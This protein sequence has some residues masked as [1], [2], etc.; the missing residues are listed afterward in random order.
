MIA[1]FFGHDREALARIGLGEGT[2]IGARMLTAATAFARAAGGAPAAECEALALRVVGGRRAAGERERAVLVGRAGRADRCRQ[3]AHRPLAGDHAR[4][5]APERLGVLDSPRSSCG[6]ACTCSAPATSR[7]RA[8]RC[9]RRNRLQELWG[10]APTA[11]SWARGLLAYH[12]VL[13]GDAAGARATLGEAPAAEEES[14]GAN[15]WRRAHAELLLGDGPGR[16]GARGRRADGSHRAPRAAPR[17][18]AVAVAEGAR[19]RAARPPRRGDRRDRGRARARARRR[20]A[21]ARSA[22]ACAS[23]ASSTQDAERPA[24]GRRHAGAARRRGSSTPA[25]W[26]R[27]APRCAAT[28]APPTRASRCARRSSWPRRAPARRSSSPCAPSS[29]PSGARPRTRGARR[30]RRA[31]RQRAARGH[32]RRRRADEPRDRPGAVRD[33]EDRRGPPVE[34]LPQAR[35]PLAAG[36]ARWRSAAL[37]ARAA[38]LAARPASAP[39]RFASALL[40][41]RG[42]PRDLVSSLRDLGALGGRELAPAGLQPQVDDQRTAAQ[43]GPRDLALRRQ[44]ARLRHCSQATRPCADGSGRRGS[45]HVARGAASLGAWMARRAARRHRL[46]RPVRRA[47]G[48]PARQPDVAAGARRRAPLRRARARVR[49]DLPGRAGSPGRSTAPAEHAVDEAAEVA[50]AGRRIKQGLVLT[51][52]A[53]ALLAVATASG[54]WPQPVE[55]GGGQ[56]TVQ[57]RS[58]ERLCGSL[59]QANPGSL[60]VTVDGRPVVVSLDN[61]AT[62]A[63]GAC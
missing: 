58:G 46:H 45:S 24:R 62:I 49:R 22:A 11:T 37:D 43:L 19:A 39:S 44:S 48:R 41:F 3:P 1:V 21:G 32:A 52:T 27:S 2:G 31:D 4:A 63:P 35:H 38:A 56:V 29:T 42:R 54:W 8:S 25:R 17:L 34:R 23:S 13:T 59:G 30:R 36:V 60:S 20:R 16:G 12:Q 14:D 55:G 51:F 26:P 40:R 33:P 50:R 57:A 18:E 15:L 5:G 6:P 28:A 9:A 7:R 53:V 47:Q 61:V 10:S